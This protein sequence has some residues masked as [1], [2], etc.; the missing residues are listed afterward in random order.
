MT[1]IVHVEARCGPDTEV[2]VEIIDSRY[3]D[4]NENY[5]LDDGHKGS[6]N[7]YEE[8]SLTVTEVDKETQGDALDPATDAFEEY[9]GG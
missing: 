5:I 6:Y 9:R 2:H 3:P 4:S 1:S 8:R 7:V